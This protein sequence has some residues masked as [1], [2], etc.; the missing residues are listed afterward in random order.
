MRYPT[1]DKP[2]PV[3][4]LGPI[5]SLDT[6]GTTRGGW[7]PDRAPDEPR[8]VRATGGPETEPD[9]T[10]NRPPMRVWVPRVVQVPQEG[11]S[12][13]RTSF[14]L[15]SPAPFRPQQTAP[16]RTARRAAHCEPVIDFSGRCAKISRIGCFSASEWGS[17]VLT[18]CGSCGIVQFKQL[19]KKPVA[20]LL[21]HALVVHQTGIGPS[22]RK[23]E[24]EEL[25]AWLS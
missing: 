6:R 18:L 1:G 9:R 4:Q 22:L 17:Q 23:G 15:P 5:I 13:D 14:P 3:A 16:R 20:L 19:R 24:C 11:L 21:G 7:G 8:G 10:P 12:L 2:S 25:Q